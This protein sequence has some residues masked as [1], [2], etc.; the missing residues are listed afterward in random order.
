MNKTDSEFDPY[1]G[2][3]GYTIYKKNLSEAQQAS[4]RK[5]LTVKPFAPKTSIQ[6]P[7]PFPIYREAPKNSTFRACS[8]SKNSEKWTTTKYP[9]VNR[10]R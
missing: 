1:I 6:Q 3:K 10:F 7:T 2:P 9:M 5:E 8:E 4:I